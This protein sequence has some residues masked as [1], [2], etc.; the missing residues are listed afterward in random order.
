[1]D[2]LLFLTPDTCLV[3]CYH[4]CLPCPP[5]LNVSITLFSFYTVA[6]DTSSVISW[7]W[8]ITHM[9]AT[10]W[11]RLWTNKHTRAHSVIIH[12]PLNPSAKL[13]YALPWYLSTLQMMSCLVIPLPQENSLHVC[14][15]VCLGR[16]YE[17][18]CIPRI[19]VLSLSSMLLTQ[20]MAPP[21]HP[22]SKHSNSLMTPHWHQCKMGQPAVIFECRQTNWSLMCRKQ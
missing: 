17:H 22:L 7:I 19:C 8:H 18:R 12:F 10:H 2:N 15:R 16:D 5:P 1:M 13:H 20:I 6:C 11:Y 14:V 3:T 4:F 21:V 9:H